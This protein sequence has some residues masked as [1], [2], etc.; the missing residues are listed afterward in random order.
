MIR[1]GCVMAQTYWISK[2]GSTCYLDK[3]LKVV[4]DNT[5]TAP[6]EIGGGILKNV[7]TTIPVLD[8]LGTG[9]FFVSISLWFE[10]QS[11]RRDLVWMAAGSGASAWD[12]WWWLLAPTTGRR[13]TWCHR[14]HLGFIGWQK[15]DWGVGRVCYGAGNLWVRCKTWKME[16]SWSL[17]LV[18]RPFWGT[19]ILFLEAKKTTF[20]GGHCGAAA[21]NWK[22]AVLHGRSKGSP[23]TQCDPISERPRPRGGILSHSERWTFCVIF[24]RFKSHTLANFTP[25]S[26][27]DVWRWFW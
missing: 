18:L 2:T 4:P 23:A 15:F 11:T 10:T 13:R 7:S 27:F 26:I 3:S 1:R 9:P 16:V 8:L 6:F 17:E 21:V 25:H 22:S 19:E 14:S 24:Q 20:F 5:P 12:C